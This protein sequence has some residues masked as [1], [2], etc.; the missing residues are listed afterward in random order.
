MIHRRY[1]S[2]SDVHQRIEDHVSNE[3]AV[4][5]FALQAELVSD[6]PGDRTALT[7]HSAI[8]ELQHWQRAK[9]RLCN[10]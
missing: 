2:F 8:F 6:E 1:D 10:R 3:P 7:N 4:L 5:V 9:R